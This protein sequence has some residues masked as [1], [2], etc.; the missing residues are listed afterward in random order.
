MHS[1]VTGHVALLEHRSQLAQAAGTSVN[2]CWR[3]RCARS[4][5]L[6]LSVAIRGHRLQERPLPDGSLARPRGRAL[7]S[8]RCPCQAHKRLGCMV[9]SR[10][11]RGLLGTVCLRSSM[12]SS[13]RPSS[14]A[15]WREAAMPGGPRAHLPWRPRRSRASLAVVAGDRDRPELEVG[16]TRSIWLCASA[17]WCRHDRSR[18]ASFLAGLG[19]ERHCQR[20]ALGVPWWGARKPRRR[21]RGWAALRR[22]VCLVE[23]WPEHARVRRR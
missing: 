2:W 3:T 6:P 18:R 16:P 12:A 11:R 17:R 23:D 4:L 7:P 9:P 1:A 19:P 10:E 8:A 15:A 13:I 20:R 14:R 5:L 22:A 21:I